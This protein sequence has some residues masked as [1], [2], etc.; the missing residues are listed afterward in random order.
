MPNST[1]LVSDSL[2]GRTH[3]HPGGP[4]QRGLPAVLPQAEARIQ[5][6]REGG[7]FAQE[8]IFKLTER[9]QIRTIM[10]HSEENV[11]GEG[12]PKT[13]FVL[14]CSGQPS[15]RIFF[16]WNVFLITEGT[17][18]GR[19]P[20]IGFAVSSRQRSIFPDHSLA[21]RMPSPVFLKEFLIATLV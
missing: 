20:R 13:V 8:K 5:V 14:L 10:G 3:H 21:G 11:T 12:H 17:S 4:G 16:I 18:W 2:A 19:P 7:E 9:H 15:T 6:G 1:Q